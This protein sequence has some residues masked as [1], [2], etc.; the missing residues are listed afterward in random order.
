MNTIT[1][2]IQD[3]RLAFMNKHYTK[4]VECTLR[5]DEGHTATAYLHGHL[6]AGLIECHVTEETDTCEHENTHTESNEVTNF[7][8]PDIDSSYDIDVEVC[9]VCDCAV[10]AI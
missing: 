6:W 9:D 10:E 3:R 5:P 1:G 8:T 7:S 4:N 2:A